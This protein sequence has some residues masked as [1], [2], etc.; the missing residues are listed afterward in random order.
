VVLQ[1]GQTDAQGAAVAEALMDALGL[2][3][4][5]RLAGSYLDMLAGKALAAAN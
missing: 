2:A 1:G 3:G 4:A 5:P